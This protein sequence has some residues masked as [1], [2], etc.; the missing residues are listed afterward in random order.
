MANKIER[1]IDTSTI[2]GSALDA[3]QEMART[4]TGGCGDCVLHFGTNFNPSISGLTLTFNSSKAVVGGCL[5][6]NYSSIFNLEAV[7][8]YIIYV[9]VSY[10]SSSQKGSSKIVAETT[11]SL[12]EA[13]LLFPGDDLLVLEKAFPVRRLPLFYCSTDSSNIEIVKDLRPKSEVEK[14]NEKITELENSK[15]WAKMANYRTYTITT[16]RKEIAMST[17]TIFQDDNFPIFETGT[18]VFAKDFSAVNVNLAAR[19]RG[20]ANVATGHVITNIAHYRGTEELDSYSTITTTIYNS[21]RSITNVNYIFN[22]IKQGDK[23]VFR[24][25]SGGNSNFSLEVAFATINVL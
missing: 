8:N 7:E 2:L 22:D 18:Q 21:A 5:V 6:D 23:L 3:F 13:M 15:G 16:T 19:G 12:E 10:D 4:F 17:D 9:Q 20:V 14:A 25:T 11:E 1:D 24:F